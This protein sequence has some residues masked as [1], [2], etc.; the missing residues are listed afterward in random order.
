MA[1]LCNINHDNLNA[2]KDQSRQFLPTLR[3]FFEE[4]IDQL[5]PANQVEKQYLLVNKTDWSWKALRLLAKRSAFYFMQNQNVRSI[6]EYLEAICHKLAK[7]FQVNQSEQA[8]TNESESTPMNDDE[9]VQ[10]N[11]EMVQS[12]PVAN[13]TTNVNVSTAENVNIES[14]ETNQMT[15]E[16]RLLKLKQEFQMD[17]Y[18][19]DSQSSTQSNTPPRR[20]KCEIKIEETQ[21]FSMETNQSPLV[22]K[23]S[24]MV[25]EMFM[26]SLSNNI[27]SV[28]DW[29][30]LAEA[31]LMDEDTIAFIE[32]DVSDV[33]KQCKRILQLW[34]VSSLSYWSKIYSKIK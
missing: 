21:A 1:K 23:S 12:T 29:K 18:Q 16:E 3:D 34:K 6:P 9:S 4:P 10:L 7:E 33:K 22:D 26:D 20:I 15:H 30:K 25:D 14:K 8:G 2:C 27:K 13:H 17:E 5:D 19:E 32:S 11:D 24:E 28:N 31:L